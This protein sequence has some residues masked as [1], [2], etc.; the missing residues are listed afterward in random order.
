MRAHTAS[1]KE[2]KEA[3]VEADE[4][5]EPHTDHH[6]AEPRGSLESPE[7]YD[8]DDTETAQAAPGKS[9]FLGGRGMW[10]SASLTNTK[11]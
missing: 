11:H 6:D 4:H 7:D 2:I 3:I 10:F 9:T 1:E 5:D 8:E